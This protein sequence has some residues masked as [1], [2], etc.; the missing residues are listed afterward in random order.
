[1]SYTPGP[2]TL[3]T[4]RTSIGSC[5]KIGPFPSHG[6]RDTTHA[7]VYVDGVAP[8]QQTTISHELLA[9]ARLIAAAPTMLEALRACADRMA[10]AAARA[11][12]LAIDEPSLIAAVEAIAKA[13]GQL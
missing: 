12:K 8:D 11:E 4:V 6:S 10:I 2:W 1:V 9:N 5:H 7:C 13:E 3:D